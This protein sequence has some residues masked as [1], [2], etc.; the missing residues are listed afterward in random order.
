MKREKIK[1][2]YGRRVRRVIGHFAGVINPLIAVTPHTGPKPKKR[3]GR[4]C[5]ALGD[6][7]VCY[8]L[9]SLARG[10]TP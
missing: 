8:S 9:H 2:N 4:L 6:C 5:C 7:N 1:I 3:R 10:T